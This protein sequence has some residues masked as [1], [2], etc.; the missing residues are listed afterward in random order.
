MKKTKLLALLCIFALLIGVFAACQ[1]EENV[2]TT[3]APST[4]ENVEENTVAANVSVLK[5]PTGMGAA[6]LMSRNEAKES[7]GG[8]EFTI[9]SAPDVVVSALLAGNTDIA[10]IPTTSAA[11][12]YNK[13]NGKIKILGISTLSVLY[14]MEKGET[15]TDVK[16]LEG[17]TIVTSGKGTNVEYVLNYILEKNNLTPGENVTVTFVSEHAEA[18]TQA[19]AG[20]ADIVLLPEPFV[21]QLKAA[22]V[23]FRSALDFKEEWAKVSDF[24]LPMGVIAANKEFAEKNPATIEKFME[25]YKESVTYVNAESTLAD[26]A[27]LIGGYEIMP[28][29]IAKAAIPNS[30]IV[31][32]TGSEMKDIVSDFFTKMFEANPQVIGGA[33]PGEDI[34]Y[35]NNA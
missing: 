23:G 16:S 7:A 27:A 31:F 9:E 30:N 24:S 5:G 35:V 3:L 1:S 8:Y 4:T 21:T 10:A 17:K 32:I 12:L 6:R 29:N 18:V 2:T 34:Y 28:E 11:T 33:L 22:N 19:K 26:A 20:N 15:V 14:I 25:D 13:S